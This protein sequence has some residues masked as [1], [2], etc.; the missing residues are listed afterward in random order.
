MPVLPN[1]KKA[2]RASKKKYKFN[3]KIRSQVKSAIKQMRKEPNKQNL[4]SVYSMIDKAA[5]KNIF[6]KNKAAR[7][8][9][10][11]AKLVSAAS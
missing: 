5:K 6:H 4:D 1:A 11:M 2:L 7:L 8:K 3:Q 10:Q 9:S